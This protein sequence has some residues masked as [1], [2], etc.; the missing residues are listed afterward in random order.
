MKCKYREICYQIIK[1]SSHFES[2]EDVDVGMLERMYIASAYGRSQV[3]VANRGH[4]NEEVF[5][6]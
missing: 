6:C 2:L 4:I 3:T 1:I 5:L